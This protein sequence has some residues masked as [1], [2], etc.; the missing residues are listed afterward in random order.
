M[1]E[2]CRLFISDDGQQALLVTASP[3]FYLW[4]EEEEMEASGCQWWQ[5][6]PPPDARLFTSGQRGLDMDACFYPHPVS[7]EL[8]TEH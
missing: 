4:E 5:I 1:C 2:G 7:L 8:W 6:S 3:R